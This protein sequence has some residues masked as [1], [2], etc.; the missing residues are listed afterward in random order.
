LS[1]ENIA[2]QLDFVLLCRIGVVRG[3]LLLAGVVVV[4]Y[5]ASMEMPA[6]PR[7][8]IT[9]QAALEQWGLEILCIREFSR[10]NDIQ[11]KHVTSNAKNSRHFPRFSTVRKAFSDLRL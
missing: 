3:L 5:M 6:R 11:S 2:N 7:M 4:C 1:A 8:R 10:F 9:Q